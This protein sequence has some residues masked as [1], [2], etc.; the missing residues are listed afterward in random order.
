[1]PT[2]ALKSI[3]KYADTIQVLRQELRSQLQEFG[4]HEASFVSFSSPFD[5]SVETVPDQFQLQYVYLRLHENL[6]SKFHDTT[7]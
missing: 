5:V 3:L 2:D 7:L 1:M 6:K 4:K